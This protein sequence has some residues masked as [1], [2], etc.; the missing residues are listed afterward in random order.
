MRKI[1][2]NARQ[3]EQVRNRFIEAE[4][5]EDRFI[6]PK[7]G[8]RV[9]SKLKVHIVDAQN[10]QNTSH[11]VMLQQ[12]ESAAETQTRDGDSPIWNEAIMFDIVDPV[13]ELIIR[14][15]DASQNEVLVG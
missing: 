9:D 5:N 13:P 15:V 14:V 8:I 1:I 7:T 4:Q 3:R 6:N 11:T 2:D 12:E 10:L